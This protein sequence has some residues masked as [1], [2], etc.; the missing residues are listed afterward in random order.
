MTLDA[1]RKCT[2]EGQKRNKTFEKDLR[3][4]RR[5]LNIM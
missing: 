2:L 4:R 3:T 1:V 5:L